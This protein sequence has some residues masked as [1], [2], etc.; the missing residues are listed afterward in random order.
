MADSSGN[1][2]PRSEAAERARCGHGIPAWTPLSEAAGRRQRRRR[3]RAAMAASKMDAEQRGPAEAVHFDMAVDNGDEAE[4]EFF[5][6]W[7]C[8][9]EEESCTRAFMGE[10]VEGVDENKVKQMGDDDDFTEEGGITEDIKDE[11]EEVQEDVVDVGAECM[12]DTAMAD[13][14]DGDVDE[15]SVIGLRDPADFQADGSADNDPRGH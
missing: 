14:D 11:V 15:E 8:N 4:K 9:M 1:S 5:P 7:A 13:H 6:D 3:L 2:A 12:E 10:H